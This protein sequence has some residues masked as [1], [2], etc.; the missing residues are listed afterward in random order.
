[1][2]HIV[3]DAFESGRR[4]SRRTQKTSTRQYTEEARNNIQIIHVP[5]EKSLNVRCAQL[6]QHKNHILV[7]LVRHVQNLKSEFEM[8]SD[9]ETFTTKYKWVFTV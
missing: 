1:M 2:M 6:S 5:D 7:K 3:S 4:R 9:A 8:W